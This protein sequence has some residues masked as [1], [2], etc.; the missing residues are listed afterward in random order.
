M[1]GA[2]LKS[3]LSNLRSGMGSSQA[4]GSEYCWSNRH[5]SDVDS[6]LSGSTEG[7]S[8]RW[9]FLHPL[10]MMHVAQIFAKAFIL[11]IFFFG[12]WHK[13]THGSQ[14]FSGT[15]SFREFVDRLN[16]PHAYIDTQTNKHINVYRLPIPHL[17]LA[18]ASQ[19][20]LPLPFIRT[21]G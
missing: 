17:L 12:S 2:S 8:R 14:S 1:C 9:P 20:A 13:H 11:Y 4:S 5:C 3:H 21:L 16:I 15:Y 18:P 19:I 7:W 6:I 10:F